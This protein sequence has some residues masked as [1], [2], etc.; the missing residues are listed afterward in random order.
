MLW[1]DLTEPVLGPVGNVTV[2]VGDALGDDESDMLL[3]AR[4]DAAMAAMM[5]SEATTTKIAGAW[6]LD[7]IQAEET[8]LS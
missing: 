3:V 7:F 5:R 6:S 1:N 2:E 4:E 8:R